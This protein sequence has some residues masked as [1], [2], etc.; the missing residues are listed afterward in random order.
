MDMEV[1]YATFA[2]SVSNKAYSYKGEEGRAS[3]KIQVPRFTLE[4]LDAGS[5]FAAMLQ[6]ALIDYDTP[7]EEEKE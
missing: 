6:A 2:V 4:S 5:L 3:I 7:E 1:I